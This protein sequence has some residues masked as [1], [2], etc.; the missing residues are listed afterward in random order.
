MLSLIHA[1]DDFLTPPSSASSSAAAPAARAS[2]LLVFGRCRR[3]K[4]NNMHMLRLHA[5]A[6]VYHMYT[7]LTLKFDAGGNYDLLPQ[8]STGHLFG[9]LH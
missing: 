1:L 7:L 9:I 5:H 3:E 8:V 6:A 4:Q 2:L